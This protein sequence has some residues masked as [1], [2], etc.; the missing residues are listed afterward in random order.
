MNQ[1]QLQ[2]K[3][4]GTNY[5]LLTTSEEFDSSGEGSLDQ[6]TCLLPYWRE[7]DLEDLARKSKLDN[8]AGR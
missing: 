4:L 6:V 8:P 5:T 3:N 1:T 7:D 2:N